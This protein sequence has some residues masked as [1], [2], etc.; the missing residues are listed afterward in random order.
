MAYNFNSSLIQKKFMLSVMKKNC[1]F[2]TKTPMPIP[3]Q[4]HQYIDEEMR[5]W[6]VEHLPYGGFDIM[7]DPN[8]FSSSRIIFSYKEDN[9]LFL[10]EFG[11]KIAE[12]NAR[13]QQ[14]KQEKFVELVYRHTDER[15]AFFDREEAERK[16]FLARLDSE[17][18]VFLNQAV[19]EKV[20]IVPPVEKISLDDG[21]VVKHNGYDD[22]LPRFAN[23]ISDVKQQLSGEKSLHCKAHKVVVEILPILEKFYYK[24]KVDFTTEEIRSEINKERAAKKTSLFTDNHSLANALRALKNFKLIEQAEAGVRGYYKLIKD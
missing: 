15:K 11:E 22:I 8:K 1:S 18:A 21:I 10:K 13:K 6:C 3:N 14:T 20:S 4:G 19:E 5:I 2:A 9:D 7:I 23:R 24:G 17:M 16:Q 12:I